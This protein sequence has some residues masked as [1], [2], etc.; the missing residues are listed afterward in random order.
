[1]ALKP[2]GVGQYFEDGVLVREEHTSTCRHCRHVTEFP[3]RKVMMEHVDICR[4]C[5]SLI[6]LNC[7]GKPCVP[8]ERRA[9]IIEQQHKMRQRMIVDGWRCY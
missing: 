5:M 1:M 9:E 7:Y 8:F 4:G 3:S 2:G 6:C